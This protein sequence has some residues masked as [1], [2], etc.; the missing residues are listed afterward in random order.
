VPWAGLNCVKTESVLGSR[1]GLNGVK[2]ESV[3]G[4]RDCSCKLGAV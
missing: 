1:D 4:S 2:T 3:L